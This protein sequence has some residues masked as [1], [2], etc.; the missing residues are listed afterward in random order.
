MFE[1]QGRELLRLIEYLR[2]LGW[3]ETEIVKLLEYINK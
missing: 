1:V 2:S 3:K